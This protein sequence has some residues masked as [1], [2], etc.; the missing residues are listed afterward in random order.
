MHE[1][2][3]KGQSQMEAKKDAEITRLRH[4]FQQL[5]SDQTDLYLKEKMEFE[6]WKKTIPRGILLIMQELRDY[7]FSLQ[8]IADFTSD[9]RAAL[10]AQQALL[11]NVR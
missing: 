9:N 6:A 5:V 2:F 3:W 8:E 11:K 1:D 10:S 7:K 4:E